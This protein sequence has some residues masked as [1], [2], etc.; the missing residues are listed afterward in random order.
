MVTVNEI[1]Q[2]DLYFALRGGMNNFGIVTHMTMRAVPQRQYYSG[3]RTYTADK[4]DPIIEQAYKLTT[5]WK[6]DTAMSFYYSLGY[7]QTTDEFDISF[8]QEYSQPIVNPVPFEELSRI[9]F[10]SDTNRIDWPSKF[11]EEVNSADPPGDRYATL[12]NPLRLS[13]IE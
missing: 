2:P 13:L 10:E 9:P 6:N 11:S 5:D 7:N 3:A 4:S 8:T 12:P 1:T